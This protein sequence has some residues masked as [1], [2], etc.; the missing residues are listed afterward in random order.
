M[1]QVLDVLNAAV[2][3]S[4][5]K[6]ALVVVPLLYLIG[7]ATAVD[8]VMTSRTPQGATAWIFALVAF[9]GLAVPLY[10]I[11]GR[12]GFKDYLEALADYDDDIEQTLCRRLDGPPF[13]PEPAEGRDVGERQAFDRLGTIPFSCGNAARLLV[14]GDATFEALFAAIDRAEHYVLA[15]FYIVHDDRIGRDFQDRLLRAAARGVSVRFL[16]DA[17]GSMGLGRRYLRTLRAGGVEVASFTGPR[18]WLKKLRLNFRNHRKIVVV[19]GREAFVGG[20]N[21]G[22]EYLGR[23]ESIGPWRDTHLAVEGPAVQALQLSFSKDWYY[24]RRESLAELV[25]EPQAAPADTTALVLAS[26]PADAVETCGLLY[27]H[28]IESAEERLWIATPYFVPDGRVLG[29]LELAALRGADVRVLVP[30]KSDSLFFRFAPFAYLEEVTRVGVKVYL[31]EEGFMHQKVLLVDRDFA[32]V[33]TA[34]F[35]N[36]SFRLNFETTVV[37]QNAAFCDDVAAMLEAD[38]ARA[39]PVPLETLEGASF[40]FRFAAGVTRLLAPVL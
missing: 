12:F 15:Q 39:T 18:N 34:N 2:P 4:V 9:P 6:A 8:A 38:F 10:W 19:D 29:A 26:G 35:D 32:T 25:W 23:D 11:V 30:R 7:V 37:V 24:A 5:G 3:F 13:T 20:F 16:Y 21:V 17:V 14:D 27:T 22:D 40:W 28:A 31:Y 36:R 1:E 33:G